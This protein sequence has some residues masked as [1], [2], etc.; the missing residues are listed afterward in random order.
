MGQKGKRKLGYN[1][2]IYSLSGS[3]VTMIEIH[4]EGYK[5]K[6]IGKCRYNVT[7]GD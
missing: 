4:S 1:K 7:L 2:V 3:L 6:Y 5:K